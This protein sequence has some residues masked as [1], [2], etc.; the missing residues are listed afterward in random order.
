MQKKHVLFSGFI[1]TLF[2]WIVAF[3]ML[4]TRFNSQLGDSGI[5]TLRVL[6]DAQ[7]PENPVVT[8]FPNTEVIQQDEPT[9]NDDIVDADDNN[10]TAAP[11]D[12]IVA[13]ESGSDS[14]TESI[15]GNNTPVQQVVNRPNVEP[16][17]IV[18][19]QVAVPNEVVLHFDPNSTAQQREEYVRSFGGTISQTIESLNTI[20]VDVP[21]A[22]TMNTLPPSSIVMVSEP[23]Y[24]ASALI[25]V[26]TSDPYYDE[27]WA[28]PV[29]GA[30]DAWQQL[31]DDAPMVTIAVID[32]GVCLN[33]P[34]LAGHILSGYD[35]VENDTTPEDAL[36]HGCGVA[37]II[38]ANI[39][40]DIGI[41][42][43]APNAMIIPLR[44]LDA[45]GVG[46]YAD[47]AAAM[48]YA[49]DNGAQI[50]NLSLGGVY[51][52]TV[53]EDAVNYAI[54]HDV[55]VI[56]AAGNT[57]G[58]VLYPAA[59]ELVIAVGS[60]DPNLQLSSF[61]ANGAEVDLWAPGRDIMTTSLD[62]S[63]SMMSGTSFAAPNVSGLHAIGINI[64][65]I[66]PD[67]TE[68]PPTA[69]PSTTLTPYYDDLLA[70]VRANSR[71]RVIVALDVTFQSEE[72]LAPQAVQDQRAA[73]QEVQMNL[74]N[75]ISSNNVTTLAAY[76]VIPYLAL[77]VDELVLISLINSPMVIGIEEDRF[78]STS[79]DSSIPIVGA[80]NAWAM[81]YRGGGQTV[82]IL[83]TGVDSSHVFLQGR[84]VEEAC[85][86]SRGLFGL[87]DSLCP[88]GETSQTGT[89]AAS[90]HACVG[91]TDCYHG[92][93][94]TGI[95]AGSNGQFGSIA[96]SGVAP[97]A[98][99]FAIQVF[100]V[101]I[102]GRLRA[103]DSDIIQG[104]QR[105]FERRNEAH[106]GSIVAVNLS[107]GDGEMHRG[108][109]CDTP[110]NS[111][112]RAIVDVLR[113]ANI[114]TIAASGNEQYTHGINYPG[115]LSN[116]IS[117]GSTNDTDQIAN[118]SNSGLA[119]NLLAPGFNITTS[120]F[121]I[122]SPL[123]NNDF[124][125]GHG[126]SF[127]APHVTGAWA[128]LRSCAP[129]A[130]VDQVLS[131]LNTTGHSIRDARNNIVRS[132]IQ[133][134]EALRQLG[135]DPDEPPDPT[136]EPP[137]PPLPPDNPTPSGNP[138]YVVTNVSYPLNV[139][140]GQQF[141]PEIT[142]CLYNG[143]SMRESS[144]D[145][146]RSV[147]DNRF[148]AFPHVAVVGTVNSGNCYIFRFYN[149]YPITAPMQDGTYTSQ[150]KLWVNGQWVRGTEVVIEFTVGSGGVPT[151]PT[152]ILHDNSTYS[153]DS[154]GYGVGRHDIGNTNFND[155]ATSVTVP[156]DW[157]VRLYEEGGLVGNSI[158]I[159]EDTPELPAPFANAI[160]SL[161]VFS[162]STCYD[163]DEVPILDC[164]GV[165]LHDGGGRWLVLES[166]D[167]NLADDGWNDRTRWIEVIGPWRATGYDGY[168]FQDR[169][170]GPFSSG[171]N[172]V[173]T[174]VSSVRVE[175]TRPCDAPVP[176]DA[177]EICLGDSS[178]W[179][180][181]IV[182]R[183]GERMQ[184]TSSLGNLAVLP[185]DWNG[186]VDSMEVLGP[187]RG[188]PYD[189]AYW[190]GGFHDEVIQETS[191]RINLGTNVSSIRVEL[192][193]DC[194]N[195]PRP[196]QAPVDFNVSATLD[197]I[198]LSWNNVDGENGYRVYRWNGTDFVRVAEL[199]ADVTTFTD[200]GLNCAELY[201][202]QVRSFNSVG[203]S[204][205]A[206]VQADCVPNDSPQTAINVTGLPWTFTQPTNGAQAS[207]GA[208]IPLCGFN[209]GRM[210]W[211]RYTAASDNLIYINTAGSDFDTVLAVFTGIPSDLTEIICNDDEGVAVSSLAE[212]KLQTVSD[213]IGLTSLIELRP[214]AGTTYYVMIGGYNSMGGNLVFSMSPN[215]P[216]VVSV[217]SASVVFNEGEIATNGGF[218]GDPE[219][220]FVTLTASIGNVINNGDGTWS[221]NVTTS[222]GPAD[223]QTITITGDDN[224]GGTT[225]TTFNLTVNNVA[226][227]AT[228]TN[229][230]GIIPRGGTAMLAFNDS[231]DSSSVD[232]AAGFRYSV[233]CESDGVFE[234]IDSTTTS[235][236]CTYSISGSYSVLGRIKDKDGGF[237]DYTVIVIVNTPPD[238]VDD[239]VTIDE[240]NPITISV[241]A[242]D[243]DADGDTLTIASLGTASQGTVVNNGD[244]TVTYSPN[245]DYFGTDSFIYSISDGQG[246]SDTATVF[247]TI[248]PVNDPPVVTVTQ[249]SVVVNEGETASNDITTSDVEGDS[250]TVNVSVGTL[251]PTGVGTWNWSYAT[252][253]GP[254]QS[255]MVTV[256]ADDGNGGT[257]QATF[258]LTVNNVPP[259]VNAGADV[260]LISG[261]TLNI[262]A[263]FTDP[264][265]LDTHTATIDFNLGMG[266]QP[267]LVTQGTGSGTVTSSQVYY[268]IGLF[269]VTVCVT[270]DDGGVSCDSLLLEVNPLPVAIDIRPGS[271]QNTINLGSNGNVQVAILSAPGF[272][273]TTVDPLSVTLSSASV[274][275]RGNG[276]PQTNTRDVNGDG[277][278]DLVVHVDT[279]A[280]QLNDT[281]VQAVLTARAADGR[282][283]QGTDMVRIV[284]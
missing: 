60:I 123:P 33:H 131:V 111:A 252:S 25:D 175:Q 109:D 219:G 223:T 1:I 101:D 172:G 210:V 243:T 254:T 272:D 238:A 107:L 159:T 261:E 139:N 83:D 6:P 95:A 220:D 218:V 242:N 117:V 88:N 268:P 30:P 90:P 56:A 145:M 100:S 102:F 192:R 140:Q 259:S 105:V 255:Q 4:S 49:V 115:C 112:Y 5:P 240:D 50:I 34:D 106:V 257:S 67:P 176:S 14:P 274:N 20:I 94:V 282:Y 237:T 179:G 118:H 169:S 68:S 153:G 125:T 209:V 204:T 276:T 54:S 231:A 157:S 61:S 42:G 128:I 203:E 62:N 150:W 217:D 133:I 162:N 228:F 126:T 194:T 142:V 246:G 193:L 185:G 70:I 156:P 108:S 200:T 201:Y 212:V 275:L 241:L 40:N 137:I 180:V 44:V 65:P 77:E 170:H 211:Y 93:G 127:A 91:I 52:S 196:P 51:P 38:A 258:N 230:S 66:L 55:T 144:G 267:A 35:F 215:E 99:I 85:Y 23:N 163:I 225:Q 129:Q 279:E 239:L 177:P 13:Q 198:T 12:V 104:L 277:L 265:T 113:S 226:P 167:A 266:V 197:S 82:A 75:S 221:W 24:Y 22:V 190:E 132:R 120:T 174:N 119:L 227:T 32:S 92:T 15:D 284:P 110:G 26:P 97:S 63:Y 191:P 37:G 278:T 96:L 195:P 53:L 247:I 248:N 89:G 143:V 136:D 233:D 232:T 2:V 256:S 9:T 206:L 134:D 164:G 189:N 182:K 84:V 158:C 173:G 28:L 202:Y 181:Y 41:A 8:D 152:V 184:L 80:N 7:Q 48:I 43:V 213:F 58:V 205:P 122:I 207:D 270:D 253:D 283:I 216:P 264:S 59:Y 160:S 168:D 81:G 250:V 281:D 151:G 103:Y 148:G 19:P 166:S 165:I 171:I 273:A 57:G 245:L 199:A 146:L 183:N 64:L 141:H 86:S 187:Y 76:W 3:A 234:A 161:H 29:I 10:P 138:D 269:T 98:N 186:N 79:L 154:R 71:I 147:D 235:F 21:N 251:T 74:L 124:A 73:I 69:L 87:L 121:D 280:I 149:D 78:V 130:T 31:P 249:S 224:N 114:A 27:Q 11:T 45:R 155:R 263:F 208:P 39:D 222:D 244:G 17:A 47:V 135:C 18:P 260:T 262:S 46:T 271:P 188:Y 16:I 72:H 116:I 236:A 229:T 36:G 214:T 178:Q